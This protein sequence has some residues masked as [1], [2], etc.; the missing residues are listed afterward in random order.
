MHPFSQ[1]AFSQF[2]FS[3]YAFGPYDVPFLSAFS[4]LSIETNSPSTMNLSVRF[5]LCMLSVRLSI[6]F[7]YDD[8]HLKS[9]SALISPHDVH[10]MF[11]L[12][13]PFDYRPFLYAFCPLPS[14]HSFPPAT[15]RSAPAFFPYFY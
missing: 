4:P 6:C 13:S 2:A 5:I 3:Q 12:G 14:L 7:L 15:A 11:A 8:V 10:I 9:V 1:F